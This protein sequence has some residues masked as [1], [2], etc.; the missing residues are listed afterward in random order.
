MWRA[1]VEK[2]NISPVWSIWRVLDEMPKSSR[3]GVLK[4]S[5]F[6]VFLFLG[7]RLQ[8]E[9]KKK[10]EK[11]KQTNKQTRET[12][13]NKKGR[14]NHTG[15]GDQAWVTQWGYCPQREPGS[16]GDQES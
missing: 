3:E 7:V 11:I 5:S 6:A 4:L 2:M 12:K 13:P 1:T 16:S 8:P 15:R 10:I 14:G 9:K